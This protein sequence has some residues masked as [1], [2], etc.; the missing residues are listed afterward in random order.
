MIPYDL[1]TSVSTGGHIGIFPQ[2]SWNAFSYWYSPD[3]I[4]SCGNLYRSVWTM[5]STTANPNLTISFRLRINQRGSWSAWERIINS[6]KNVAPSSSSWKDYDLYFD[7]LC[8]GSDDD[9]FI[10]NFDL[11]SFD[12]SDNINSGV[13]LEHLVIDEVEITSSTQIVIHDFEG[14]PDGWVFRGVVPPFDVPV[15]S[16]DGSGLAM[17]PAGSTYSFSYWLG[18]DIPAFQGTMYRILWDVQTTVSDPDDAIQFRLR[19]NQRQS[20]AAWERIVNSNNSHAP[21]ITQ[22]KTYNVI[23]NPVTTDPLIF[24]FDCISFDFFDD[25][26]SWLYLHDVT[27]ESVEIQP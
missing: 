7:P 6:N 12:S 20:W 8:L 4:L 18:P 5:S 15:T 2:G 19:V 22:A 10:L 23:V 14:T 26:N 17:S 16:Y 3:V 9:T 1:P 25:Y 13:L 24:N 21:S 11:L 27:L